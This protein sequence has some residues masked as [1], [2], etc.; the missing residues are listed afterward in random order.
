MPISWAGATNQVWRDMEVPLR[1]RRCVRLRF[2]GMV[3]GS[4]GGR[5]GD[6]SHFEAS[7]FGVYCFHN[8]RIAEDRG[9]DIPL[10][11]GHP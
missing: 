2:K 11:E 8:G 10:A 4:F 9:A 6:G 1:R 3:T 5:T 7:V